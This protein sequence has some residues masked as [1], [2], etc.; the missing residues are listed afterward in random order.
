MITPEGIISY[1]AIWEARENPSGIMKFGC[2]LLFDKQNIKALEEEVAKATEKG[3]SSIWKG[4][5]PK[6]RYPALRDGDAELESGEK[7]DPIYKG[8]VFFN[9]SANDAPQVVGPTAEVLM[10]QTKLYAGCIVRA[11]VR[12]YPYSH[13]GSVGVGWGLNSIMLVRDGK[14]LDGRVDAETAFASYAE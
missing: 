9:C 3:K 13:S 4:R 8:K 11:D 7:E 10:D 2:Q 12:A 1:P 6:F 5:V 14:R